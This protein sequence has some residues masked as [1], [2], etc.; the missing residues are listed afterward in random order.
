MWV[1]IVAAI[2]AVPL[3]LLLIPLGISYR[4]TWPRAGDNFLTVHWAF[5]L[6]RYRMRAL[7]S[8]PG[9]GKRP[10][11]GNGARAALQVMQD[12]AGRRR[13]LRFL[14]DLWRSLNAR[15]VYAHLRVGMD[16][17]ADTGRLWGIA[18][19]LAAAAAAVPNAALSIEPDFGG[20]TLSVDSG[21]RFR[22]VPLLTL[23]HIVALLLSPPVR[24]ARRLRS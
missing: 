15:G 16:D 22:C 23:Y 13:L 1:S 17:P 7:P 5:G 19:P 9:Q 14:R 10:A 3:L 2:V 21:G 8:G 6:V 11:G 4:F 24:R 12:A 20:E 18:G